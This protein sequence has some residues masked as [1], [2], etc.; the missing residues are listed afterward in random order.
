[1]QNIVKNNEISFNIIFLFI[2]SKFKSLIIILLSI[3]KDIKMKK[4]KEKNFTLCF[5][6][7]LSSK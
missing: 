1:M 4:I 5:K 3:S 7:N 6:L 2:K